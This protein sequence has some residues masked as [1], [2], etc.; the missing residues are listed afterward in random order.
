MSSENIGTQQSQAIMVEG[1]QSIPAS[2][3]QIENTWTSLVPMVLIFVVFYFLLIRPQE[4][5]RKAQEA[6]VS[7]V[8]VGEDIITNSG[9]YG[10]VASINES[11]NTVSILISEGVAIKILKSAISD[12]ISRV[13][14]QSKVEDKAQDNKVKSKKSGK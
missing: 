14:T 5:K 8:K 9:I 13:N 10:K 7:G 2:P 12:I 6:L 4:K 1:G 3:P 11:D